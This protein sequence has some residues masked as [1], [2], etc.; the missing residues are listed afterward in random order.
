MTCSKQIE[1]NYYLKLTCTCSI[2][3][4]HMRGL[5]PQVSL[6]R[7]FFSR[8]WHFR[9]HDSLHLHLASKGTLSNFFKFSWVVHYRKTCKNHVYKQG[10]H[11]AIFAVLEI[12][13]SKILQ[14]LNK[15]DCFCL[16][17]WLHFLWCF[18]RKNWFT[19]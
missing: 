2:W 7:T 10:G 4:L 16:H 14:K 13:R 15:S 1:L 12:N 8:H 9:W 6:H 11:H 19:Q 17:S 18:S 3:F 5:Q